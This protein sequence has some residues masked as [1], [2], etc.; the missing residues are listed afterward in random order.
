MILCRD[1]Q[2]I[3]KAFCKKTCNNSWYTDLECIFCVIKFKFKSRSNSC[4]NL[5]ASYITSKPLVLYSHTYKK[6]LFIND[7][8]IYNVHIYKLYSWE[9]TQ[10]KKKPRQLAILH[11]LFDQS[12]NGT[13]MLHTCNATTNHTI[14]ESLVFHWV[15]SCL[16]SLFPR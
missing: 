3:E 4:L 6:I 10:K 7:L 12:R 5:L 1:F 14:T 11:M 8:N 16:V 2:S 15:A 9:E 13:T